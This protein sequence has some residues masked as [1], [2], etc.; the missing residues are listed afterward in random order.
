[1]DFARDHVDLFAR[2]FQGNQDVFGSH[3]PE[4]NPVE[5]EKAKGKSWTKTEPLT[6]EHYLKHLHGEESIGVVPIDGNGNVRFAAID[7]DVYPLDPQKYLNILKRSSLPFV[8]FRSKSGGLHLYC[9]FSVDTSA[10]K[11]L[12]MLQL[13]RQLLGL[14]E[15]TEIF[16]KQSRLLPGS[17]G[18]WINLPYFDYKGTARPAYDLDGNQLEL[19]EG[20]NFCKKVQTTLKDFA[21]ALANLPMAEAPPCLQTIFLS[22]GADE[23]ERNRYLFNC[24][25]Y[26]KARF[27]EDFSINLHELNSRMD[28]PVEFEELDR[29][30]V[31]SHNKGDYSYQCSEPVLKQHCNRTL[32]S[33]RQF[34]KG[35]SAVSD[36]SFEQLTQVLSSTPYYK[37]VVNGAEMVFYSE[38]ELMNQ[39]K[40]RELCLR[41]LH[42]VPNRLKDGAWNSVLN[43]ALENLEEQEVESDDDLSEESLWFSKVS[44]FFSRRK[45]M[46]PS[47]IEEG[48]VYHGE[49]GVLYF[50]GAKLLEYLDRT[51]LFFSF[52][53]SQHKTLLDQLS[54]R[55]LKMRYPEIGRSGRAWAV[56][57][58]TLKTKGIVVDLQN[59]E[60][61]EA[62]IDP[63]DFSKEEPF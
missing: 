35:T 30:V 63:L 9:F 31:S 5:G 17:K 1:M 49:D 47:Q 54:P 4:A 53:K 8:G 62:N 44:E 43:R 51:K 28:H 61:L 59:D 15:E 2:L 57:I 7:V 56:D 11:L 55:K 40:F 48:M 39:N 13:A 41:L 12:P 27:G 42:R 58:E 19:E 3:I 14:K 37:W 21:G 25:T 60:E 23:G 34:G 52:Q 22:G 29:T 24:A 46:R 16:P 18:N 36:L 32:C 10:A 6:F 38:A 20:L 50:K 45:A 33:Q 26:L